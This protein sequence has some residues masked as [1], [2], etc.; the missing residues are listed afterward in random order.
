MYSLTTRI[1]E[2]VLV[3]HSS[4]IL[5]TSV[6]NLGSSKP[7]SIHLHVFNAKVL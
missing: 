2:V 1:V 4:L 6:V 5:N 7:V 3:F